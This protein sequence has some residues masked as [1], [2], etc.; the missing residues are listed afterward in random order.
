MKKIV[1]I[2]AIVLS[3]SPLIM[4][5]TRSDVDV[6]SEVM[7]NTLRPGRQVL[8]MFDHQCGAKCQV[9]YARMRK[10]SVVYGES[11]YFSYINLSEVPEVARVLNI[12][13]SNL[14]ITT[15]F[16]NYQPAVNIMGVMEEDDLMTILSKFSEIEVVSNDNRRPKTK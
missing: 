3:L 6:F 12:K 7:Q 13:P 14:P 8:F 11:I 4:S 9:M 2:L 1:L 15:F 16:I 10:M 5:Q